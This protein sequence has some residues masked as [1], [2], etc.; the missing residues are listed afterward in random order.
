EAQA[1]EALALVRVDRQ[2]MA[3][4]VL[5]EPLGDEEGGQPVGE[6]DL[7]REGRAER[8]DQREEVLPLLWRHA[9]WTE[10]LLATV[11]VRDHVRLIE[12]L[13]DRIHHR[14]TRFSTASPHFFH[15]GP[16]PTRPI[17]GAL[18]R[19]RRPLLPGRPTR[20]ERR[21][22]IALFCPSFG[23][24]GGIEVKAERL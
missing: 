2:V 24:V 17:R 16:I 1:V 11:A 10:R 19:A 23:Q 20:Y 9:R 6:A 14:C 7:E 21:L 22:R 4:A 13:Q 3:A 12:A 5:T 15:R 18:A 8:T